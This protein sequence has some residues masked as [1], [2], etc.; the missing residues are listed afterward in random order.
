MHVHFLHLGREHLGIELLAAVLEQH[1]HRVSVGV[2]PGLLGPEDN[3]FYV[4]RLERLLARGERL[5][6]ETIAA[7][8]DVLAFSPYTSTVQWALEAARRIKSKVAIPTVFGGPH[9]TLVPEYLAAQPEVDYTVRG[10]G[11]QALP[12]LLDFIG[13]GADPRG[14]RNLCWRDDQGRVVNN[15]LRP[16][17]DLD[18]L[19]LPRKELFAHYS[20]PNLS[21]LIAA[22]RGCPNRCTYC[23]EGTVSDMYKRRFFRLR[24]VGKV[25]DELARAKRVWRPKEV[26]F[27]DT[28]LHVKRD[29]ALELLESY[30]NAINIPFRCFGSSQL[31]DESIALALKRAGCF[32]VQFGLQTVNDELRRDILGRN[33]PLDRSL[34]AFK[35]CDRIGLRYDV[36]IMFNLPGETSDDYRRTVEFFRGLK[37][38]NRIKCHYLTLFPGTALLDRQQ[39]VGAVD[40]EQRARIEAG[41]INDFFHEPAIDDPQ[42]LR[43]VNAATHAL[44]VLPLLPASWTERMLRNDRWTK[45]AKLPYPLLIALQ[46][47]GALRGRDHRFWTYIKYYAIMLPRA[48]RERNRAGSV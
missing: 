36:D 26:L 34:D 19:P 7:P 4:P 11:E 6:A 39:Q 41:W 2:D 25:L 38:L 3:V 20:M 13:R 47:L 48:L 12:E 9:A 23:C 29:W 37:M 42:H 1:G 35:L 8:P 33:E 44:K 16:L 17:V 31:L 45:L 18:T 32:T 24:S 46:L 22:S 43:L 28:I 14:M 5:I 40:A 27:V 21:Y 15:P 10:E 30:G